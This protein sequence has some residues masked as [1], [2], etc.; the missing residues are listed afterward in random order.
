MYLFTPPLLKLLVMKIIWCYKGLKYKGA[1]ATSECLC[2]PVDNVQHLLSLL[3]DM[4][5]YLIQFISAF[6]QLPLEGLRI[7]LDI[8]DSVKSFLM[9]RYFT[10]HALWPN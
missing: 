6:H 4:Y 7:T 9:S 3:H 2:L 10:Q 5:Q 8:C 1:V